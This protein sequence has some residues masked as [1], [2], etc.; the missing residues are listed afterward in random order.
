MRHG[1]AL[2]ERAPW[3]DLSCMNAIKSYEKK[4]CSFSDLFA[5]S[6][7]GGSDPMQGIVSLSTAA[8]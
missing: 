5:G 3:H 8:G 1:N 2:K 6:A 7:V 4:F